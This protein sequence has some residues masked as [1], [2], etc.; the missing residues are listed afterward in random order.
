MINSGIQEVD[1]DVSFEVKEEYVKKMLP[2]VYN[3]LKN[4]YSDN[5]EKFVN[6]IESIY[7]S[8]HKKVND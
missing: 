6:E 8:Y 4:K 7:G 1:K 2:P 3:V 5:K